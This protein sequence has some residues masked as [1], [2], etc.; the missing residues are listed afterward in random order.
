ME[1]H[2]GW[3]PGSSTSNSCSSAV[4]YGYSWLSDR[5][6]VDKVLPTYVDQPSMLHDVR[7]STEI[8][9]GAAN[10][11][12]PPGSGDRMNGQIVSRNERRC[13]S[14]SGCSISSPLV[15]D[16]QLSTL[17][18][19]VSTDADSTAVTVVTE[20][21]VGHPGEL[22]VTE[23]QKQSTVCRDN[24][25]VEDFGDEVQPFGD[26]SVCSVCGDVAAGFHCGAYVCE[27]CKVK[28]FTVSDV[29]R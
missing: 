18:D 28:N 3:F 14:D 23:H 22:T 16:V 1:Q 7:N 11:K 4:T 9:N 6:Y 5:L 10:A 29:V 24:I 20:A 27:A 2:T 15:D 21:D 12:L 19:T 13:G 25:S 8:Q 17:T 26:S